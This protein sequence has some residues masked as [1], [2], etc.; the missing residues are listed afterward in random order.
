[1]AQALHFSKHSA[2]LASS[3]TT[4][5]NNSGTFLRSKQYAY[6]LTSLKIPH[7][8]LG[9]KLWSRATNPLARISVHEH[10]CTNRS[11]CTKMGLQR[12]GYMLAVVYYLKDACRILSPIPMDGSNPIW[13]NLWNLNNWPKIPFFLSLLLKSWMLTW[14]KLQRRGFNGPLIC[15]L[16][17]S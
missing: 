13:K 7:F 9:H 5:A 12:W 2:G 16:C 6:N 10:S 17:K 11:R 1:M 8:I 15:M 4:W 3:T 14:E